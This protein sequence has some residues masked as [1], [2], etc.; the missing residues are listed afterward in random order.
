MKKLAALL[1]I[2]I[3]LIGGCQQKP[4]QETTGK[5]AAEP[6]TAAVDLTKRPAA[7]AP[8]S[9]ADRLVRALYFEH[10]T[11]EN[12]FLEAKDPALAEQFFT[13]PVAERLYKKAA[14]A[15]A[16][17]KQI[18]PLFNV[19]DA[20]IQKRWVLPAAVSGAKAVVFVTYNTSGKEQEMRCELEQQANGRWR[21]SDIIY[22][23]GKRLTELI[24]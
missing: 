17:R 3:L 22:A 10:D 7:D 1:T 23:D 19:P 12:P 13:K 9:A 18:N 21:I 16:S 8:R 11:K 2:T 24:K 14:A 15:S 6:T 5:P 4:A 20:Q